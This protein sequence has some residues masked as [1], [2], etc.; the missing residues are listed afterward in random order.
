MSNNINNEPILTEV[1]NRF[2]IFPIQ[3]QDLWDYYKQA[4]SAF[5]RAEE[6]DLTTDIIHWSDK[7]NDNERFF[8][9]NILAFFAA[10]DGIVNVLMRWN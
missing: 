7:L 1:A 3:H 6:I 2:V 4:E 5:W 8:I 9:K 10:S